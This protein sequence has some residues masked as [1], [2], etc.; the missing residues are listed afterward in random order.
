MSDARK[1]GPARRIRPARLGRLAAMA[2]AA[3]ASF[4]GAQ[5]TE[6][7]A[8]PQEKQLVI[9][10]VAIRTAVAGQG[11][12][13]KGWIACDGGRITAL[14]AEPIAAGVQKPDAHVIDAPGH[15][16]T[17]GLWAS[18]S[19]L[20][21]IETLQVEA[22]DDTKEFGD[23]RAEI[24]ASTATNPDSDLPPV[25]RN[26]GI[27]MVH[28][29]PAGGTV[30][31]HASAMRLDGWT[32][33]DRTAHELAGLIV[34]W[35]M[36]EP[37]QARWVQR[38]PEDQRKERDRRIAAID[39]FFDDAEAYLKA[40]AADP[41]LG[42]DARYASLEGVVAGKEPVL[43]D[44]NWPGQIEAA[45]LWA[46]R[47]GYRP[48]VFGGL[49]APEVAPLLKRHS[50]PVIVAGI[51]RL[52]LRE[53][54][55]YDAAYAVPAELVRAGVECSIASGD[56]PAHERSLP[57]QCGRAVAHGLP[58]DAALGCV[59]RV[60]AALAGVGDR[61]GTLE[62]GKSAT[63]VLWSG[64]PFELTTL[65]RRA[66]IDGGECDLNDRHKRMRAKYEEK[67]LQ[68]EPAAADDG[69]PPVVADPPKDPAP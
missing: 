52:P 47:R 9:R 22:T 56:E 3:L 15:V 29:F 28:A 61:Y 59:T 35:P 40:R 19:T 7:P 65:V 18:A 36:M 43:L 13:E 26:A 33:V 60:P 62:A 37:V 25:A 53:S 39:R 54:D 63:L 69:E 58:A 51:N 10:N 31:G 27:L 44:A 2:C 5:S 46:V 64:D 16:V 14:G 6:I 41:S 4:A 34:R 49:G 50:V 30:A 17:P 12:I 8:A 57:A 68:G 20:G 67:R 1:Q 38:T 21:L 45:V 32:A 11:A 23:F 48:V 66:W 42:V 24:K 55:P